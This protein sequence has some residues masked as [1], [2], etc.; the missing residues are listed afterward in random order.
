[1]RSPEANDNSTAQIDEFSTSIQT[2]KEQANTIITNFRTAGIMPRKTSGFATAN[3]NRKLVKALVYPETS[4]DG[5]IGSIITGM[6]VCFCI[7]M[8]W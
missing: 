5:V 3:S 7:C 8:D 2:I 1:M 4:E 6:N